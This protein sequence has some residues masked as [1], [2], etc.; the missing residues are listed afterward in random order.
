MI[1]H[2]FKVSNNVAILLYS[3]SKLNLANVLTEKSFHQKHLF[4]FDTFHYQLLFDVMKIYK[5]QIYV[6]ISDM[7]LICVGFL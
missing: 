4:F 5:H 2:T 3:A 1:Q 7:L 6:R